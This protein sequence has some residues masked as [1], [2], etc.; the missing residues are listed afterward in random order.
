MDHLQTVV[1]LA[2]DLTAALSA[3]DRYGRLLEALGRVI[4]HDASAL[5]RLEG[6]ALVPVVAR[7]LSADAL[8]RRFLIREH[9]R[10]EI[11]CRSEEPVRFP[12]DTELPDPFDGLLADD[13]GE[14]HHVHA[15]LG[16]PL[17]VEGEL[18]GVLTADSVDPGAFEEIDQVFLTAV[19]ALAAAEMRTANLL[20]ALEKSAERQGRIARDLMRDARLREGTQLIGT[21]LVMERLRRDLELVARSDFTV[22]ITGETGTGKELVARGIHDASPRS[23]EAMIYVNCAALPETLADSELFGHVK[24]AFSG[25]TSDRPGKFEVADGGTLFLDEIGELPLS[26]QA[27]LLRALQ[28]GEIQRVGTERPIRVDVRVLAATNRDLERGVEEG[29]FRADLY[30]R[31][32]VYPLRAPPLRE[33]G[34]DIPLLAG[35]FCDMIRRRLGLGPVRLVPEAVEALHRYPWPGNVRELENVLS[36]AAL[37]AAGGVEPGGPVILGLEHLGKDFSEHGEREVVFT[38]PSLPAASSPPTLREAVREFQRGF[39]Q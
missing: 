16:C 19:G 4:P 5:L 38:P 17:R 34:D 24:G 37:K 6:D 22:L 31:L 32:N 10:L 12:P 30:H 35:Y 14:F 13:D 20:D 36:R 27:K 3:E 33:R 23:E 25:A 2:L 29:E 8:G 26:V 15:C 21:S 9:P 1:S 18:I 7:G 39:I 11:I 28:E